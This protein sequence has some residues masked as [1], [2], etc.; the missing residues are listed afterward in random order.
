MRSC[1]NYFVLNHMTE[2]EQDGLF[3]NLLKEMQNTG[4]KLPLQ[5]STIAYPCYGMM[6]GSSSMPTSNSNSVI[7]KN[8]N[9]WNTSLPQAN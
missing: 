4:K 9:E 3:F 6:I 2:E 1:K 5:T 7:A 8:R